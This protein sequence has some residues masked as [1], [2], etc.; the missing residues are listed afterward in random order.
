MTGARPRVSEAPLLEADIER[1]I[2][3]YL[4]LDGWV[5]RKMEQNFS[6]RKK[7]VVGQRGMADQLCVRY[8]PTSGTPSLCVERAMY[9]QVMWLEL[10]RRTGKAM[11]HQKAWHEAERARG[12]LTLI[13]GIDFEAS[14]SGF[15]TWYRASGLRRRV[16]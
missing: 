13:A 5:C 3:D 12:A 2:V 11:A 1:A 9:T 8:G 6:E 16:E 15:M 14:I 10:K 7:K 4:A